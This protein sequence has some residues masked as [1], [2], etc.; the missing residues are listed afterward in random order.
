MAKNGFKVFDSDMHVLEPVD[1][2]QRYID[3]EFKDRAPRGLQESLIDLRVEVEGK[4]NAATGPSATKEMDEAHRD[5]LERYAVDIE[6]GFDAI[7]ARDAMDKEGIDVTVLYPT[8]GLYANAHSDMDPRFSTA[9]ARAYNNWMYDFCNAGDPKRM[10]GAAVVPIQD[11]DAAVREARRA[12]TELGFKAILLRPN[13]PKQ[14]LYFHNRHFDPLWEEIQGLGVALGFHEGSA[15]ALPAVGKDRFS[16]DDVALGHAAC[17]TMEQMLATAAMTA[18]GVL[19]RFP[20]LKVAFLEGNAAWVPFWLWRL[21]EHAETYAGPGLRG[22][23]SLTPS[24]YFYRQCYASA[25]CEETPIVKAIE[26]SRDDYIV[27][28]TDYP[29]MDAKYPEA[30]NLFLK[31]PLTQESKRK[32]LWDNCA[33]LYGF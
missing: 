4:V 17:H 10:F 27:F 9:I 12:V 30:I 3:P 18:G 8:R 15:S 24:E 13:P 23:L 31:L 2:W 28:S 7:A 20:R 21:D 5:M 22:E 19:E 6:R 1:L 14:G 26:D 32:I 29:H 11:I 33:H 16:L 25:E